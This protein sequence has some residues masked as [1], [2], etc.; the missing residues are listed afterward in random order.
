M[1]FSNA[2]WLTELGIFCKDVNHESMSIFRYFQVPTRERL[3]DDSDK[4]QKP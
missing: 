2:R 3:E 1:S 4:D